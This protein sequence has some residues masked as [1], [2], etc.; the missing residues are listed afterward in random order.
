MLDTHL[1]VR[2]RPAIAA[3]L[4]QL[5]AAIDAGMP[6]AAAARQIRVSVNIARRWLSDPSVENVPAHRC[7]ECGA[8]IVKPAC[9]ECQLRH[10]RRLA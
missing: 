7:P 8:L 6:I 1:K 9:L 4:A 2:R 3:Q 10:Q 5:I